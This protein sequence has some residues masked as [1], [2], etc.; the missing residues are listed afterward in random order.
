MANG[1]SVKVVG[2]PEFKV[3]LR[4]LSANMERKVVR[5]GAM[6]AANVFK[7]AAVANAPVLKVPRKH[8]VAGTLRRSIFA[9]RSK[10]RSKPGTELIV[11][12][13][14]Q[15]RKAAK[16]GRDAYYWRW[17]EDDHIPRGPGQKIKGGD[18]RRALERSRLLSRGKV[19]P[20]TFFMK[21]AFEANQDRAIAAFNQRIAARIEKASK[22]INRR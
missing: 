8:R 1:A 19:V 16:S 3:K 22:E 6:A 4:E 21:K 2:L 10:S 15:G 5:A 18:R 9:G 17:V 13:V 11:V 7:K 12:G 20:G 14:R